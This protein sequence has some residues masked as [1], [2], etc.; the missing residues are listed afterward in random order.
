MLIFKA[1]FGNVRL[2]V[3]YMQFTIITFIVMRYYWREM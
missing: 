2:H 3:I 1:N